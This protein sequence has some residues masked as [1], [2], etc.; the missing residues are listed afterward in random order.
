LITLFVLRKDPSKTQAFT[1]MI[2]Y[3]SLLLSFTSISVLML[4]N[5]S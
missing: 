2:T 4:Q 5:G 1:N 3:L